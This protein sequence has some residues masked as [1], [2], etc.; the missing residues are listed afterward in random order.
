MSSVKKPSKPTNHN[1]KNMP[2]KGVVPPQLAAHTFD[3]KPQN[4]NTAGN[5]SNFGELRKLIVAR[6]SELI[7]VE[8]K[9]ANGKKKTVQMTRLDR[10]ML[11][12]FESQ[13]FDKQQAIIHNGWG[14]VPDKIEVSG[15]KT[16]VVSIKK[17]EDDGST[18]T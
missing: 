13:S 6:S 3:K 16:I 9:G 10:I 17:K 12:W 14:K 1:R 7:D 5:P 11:D 8:V 15:L 2:P 4:I 18:D